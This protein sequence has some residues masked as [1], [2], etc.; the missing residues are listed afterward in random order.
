MLDLFLPKIKRLHGPTIDSRLT[1]Q[2]QARKEKDRLQAQKYYARNR[3]RLLAMM[4][5]RYQA[6]KD[7]YKAKSK[8]WDA[9]NPEKRKAIR[10]RSEAIHRNKLLR[11]EVSE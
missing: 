9:E 1:P 6:R 3:D 11:I 5:A 4:K 7:E 8:K 2:E 10:R